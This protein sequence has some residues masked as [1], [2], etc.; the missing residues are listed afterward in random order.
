MRQKETLPEMYL[1]RRLTGAGDWERLLLFVLLILSFVSP[2]AAFSQTK[3]PSSGQAKSSGTSKTAATSNASATPA[4]NPSLGAVSGTITDQA[5]EVAEGAQ[6][7]LSRDKDSKKQQVASGPNGEY[8]FANVTPGPFSLTVTAPGFDTKTFSGEV[9]AGQAFVVPAIALNITAVTASVTVELTPIE[10][11][12]QQV[13]EEIHQRV[14]GIFPNFFVS[15]EPDPAPLATRQ[16]FKLSWKSVSDPVTIVGA[17][18]LAGIYQA[19]DE[20]PGYGQGAEGY[21]KRLGAA[22]A[23]VFVGTMV[24]SAILPTLLHQDPR[25]FYQGTGTKKSRFVHAIS[26]AV[27]CKGDNQKWQPNYS[28]VLGSFASGGVSYLYYP[29]SDRSLSLV[30]QNSAVRIAE[31]SLAGLMQEFVL[32]RF[33]TIHGQKQTS[34]TSTPTQP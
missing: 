8:S 34:T 12:E 26:N 33:T 15:Y 18:A 28:G 14:L 11:A 1:L 4:Q 16:K 3:R 23:D 31:S 10:V 2:Q 32:R 27:I 5:G 25:Y 30:M 6:V 19:A 20:F 21:G 22:Y 29:A 9:K 17:A 24:G 7:E 13:T